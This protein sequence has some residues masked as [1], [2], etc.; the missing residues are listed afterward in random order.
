MRRR[1]LLLLAA[2]VLVLAAAVPALT[3]RRHPSLVAYDRVRAGMTKADLEA[4][5]GPPFNGWRMPAAYGPGFE[6]EVLINTTTL[7]HRAWEIDGGVVVVE[8]D[9]LGRAKRKVW[10]EP[11]RP[12][13]RLARLGRRWL[14]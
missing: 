4:L 10:Y 9:E 6:H 7:D 13:Q 1:R 12:L 3:P 14:P 11:E 2:A 8:L 5:L